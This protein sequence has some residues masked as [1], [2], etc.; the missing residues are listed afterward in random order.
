M[1]IL[2]VQDDLEELYAGNNNNTRVKNKNVNNNNDGIIVSS[3]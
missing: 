3:V 1:Y 2:I